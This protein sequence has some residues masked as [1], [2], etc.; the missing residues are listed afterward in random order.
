[1]TSTRRN[2]PLAAA[3]AVL[4]LSASATLA[5]PKT[6]AAPGKPDSDKPW[7]VEDPHGPYQEVAFDTDEGT[8]IALDVHPD[9]KRIVFSL[10]GDL[11]LVPIEG[12]T[13][14]RI[15]DGPGYDHPKE[16]R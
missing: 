14:T 2:V 12:G 7:K 6:E 11:Y 4:L 13:A 3:L 1:M 10:L 8:W 15:T 16:P 5:A 9:G